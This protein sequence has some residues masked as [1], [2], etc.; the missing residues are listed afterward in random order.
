ME[1]K[2]KKKTDRNEGRKRK[3]SKNG[4]KTRQIESK[5]EYPVFFGVGTNVEFVPHI[6]TSPRRFLF[7]DNN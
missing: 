3:G 1:R 5:E 4:G 6:S 2:N 7:I